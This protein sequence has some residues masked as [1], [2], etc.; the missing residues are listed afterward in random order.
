MGSRL[1]PFVPARS[2]YV[3]ITFPALSLRTSWLTCYQTGMTARI[4][5]EEKDAYARK[6]VP[7]RRYADP[8][9][10]AQGT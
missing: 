7:L 6:R 10:V 8:E 2:S 5:P 9:E 3:Y 4:S 1:I